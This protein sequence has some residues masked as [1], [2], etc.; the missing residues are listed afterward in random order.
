MG[1]GYTNHLAGDQFGIIPRV[2]D[3][4]FSEKEKRKHKN[5][6]VVKC[7]F[8]EIYKE[9]LFDLLDPSIMSKVMAG[10]EKRSN[11][12]KIKEDKNGTISIVGLREEKVDS[13]AEMSEFLVK[14]GDSRTTA[15][16][17]MNDNSSRSHAIFTITIEQH[18]IDDLYQPAE[19]ESKEEAKAAADNEFMMA[20][21]HFVDLAGCE[22]AK[23]TG[24]TGDTLKEA[25]KINMSLT[26]LGKV[27]QALSEEGKKNH[28]IP[29]RESKL[30]RILQDSLGGNSKTTMIAC[31]SPSEANYAETLSTLHYAAR[32]R[33]IQCKP[34]VNRD[35]NSQLIADLRQ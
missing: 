15:Y 14:G 22:Q 1:S 5:D 30:T 24:A 28:H 25:I 26:T 11:V 27:I 10:G 16:T 19:G 13:G 7:S 18:Q 20:K 6:I 29:Y 23:K 31:V 17:K 3:L 35:P 2:I 8:L 34:I 4:I 33:K 32:A 21:F 12:D 9:E